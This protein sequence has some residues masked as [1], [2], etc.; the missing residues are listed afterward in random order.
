[1]ACHTGAI[2]YVPGS[3]NKYTSVALGIDCEKCHG[4]GS[5]HIKL[6][7]E[8]HLVDVGE[9]TDYSIVN[10]AKL[11]VEKQFDVC[12]QCHLQGIAVPHAGKPV[13]DFRPGMRLSEVYE[14]FVEEKADPDLF[15]IASHAE[16]LQQS[17]CFIASA[18]K[19]TCI[20]CHDPHKS[21]GLTATDTHIKQCQGCHKAEQA[22]LCKAPTAT[23]ATMQGNCIS[24]H[25][26]EGGT[27]DIP[28][29][30]FH[31]HRIR[32]LKPR[33][34][35][36]LAAA[37]DYIRLRCATQVPPATGPEGLAWL[38]YYEQQDHDPRWL[39]E[40]A[41]QLPATDLYARARV[42]RY[43]Q[44]PE[45]ALVLVEEALREN[46]S[47]DLLFL[48]GELLEEVSRFEE[49]YQAYLAAAKLQ[50][51]SADAAIKTAVVLLKARPGDAAALQE[52]HATLES[53]RVRRPFDARIMVN[54]GFIALNQQQWTQAERMLAG[55]LSLDP[56]YA[57]AL[58]NMASLQFVTGHSQAARRYRD[59]LAQRHPAYPGLARLDQLLAGSA[60]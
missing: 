20:T 6:M 2:Q 50:P 53:W 59:Q 42:A 47:A 58:D 55:A 4:P 39:A 19:L 22:P 40:A 31:D 14:V 28:H 1:M 24:C 34:T 56:D 21:V 45:E 52:S 13:R 32:V 11:P 30:S 9:T 35:T 15:G 12:Q 29:V 3:K 27:R 44:A 46:T 54:L 57:Q 33:D 60:L 5:V 7:Q 38:Q 48:K 18:G 26:P 51:E 8:G 36:S 17:R 25:M 43:Q 10:P 37:A 49:A 16:R 41:R 23:Q